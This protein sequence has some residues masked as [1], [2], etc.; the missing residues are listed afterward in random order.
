MSS[1][2]PLP[3]LPQPSVLTTTGFQSSPLGKVNNGFRGDEIR[4]PSI[5]P[6]FFSAF[7]IMTSVAI[8]LLGKPNSFL[9]GLLGYLLT[10]LV[11]TL[12][13]VWD[14]LWQRRRAQNPYFVR[15][16]KYGTALRVLAV[17]GLLLAFFQCWRLAAIFGTWL[18]NG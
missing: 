1:L 13:L 3:P 4:K 2:P 5:L 7:G 9:N 6:I 12:T 14:D 15:N 18:A 16:W 10:P 17:F 8:L 11:S